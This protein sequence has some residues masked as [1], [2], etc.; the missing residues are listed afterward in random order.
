[1]RYTP[2]HKSITHKKIVNTASELFRDR[3]IGGV[4]V[5]DLMNRAGLTHGGFYA[6]FSSKE[7]LAAEA[8][9][10]AF[11]EAWQRRKQVVGEAEPGRKFLTAIQHYLTTTHRDN[12]AKG[13]IAAALASEVAHHPGPIRDAMTVGVKRWIAGVEQM[14]AEDRLDVDAHTTIATMVGAMVLSRAMADP[15]VADRFISSVRETLL[16]LARRRVS[17]VVQQ[18][19]KTSS[20][21]RAKRAR[22]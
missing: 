11:D 1:M 5:S 3:S 18:R 9:K 14:I 2:Q 21:K 8:I 4:G 10:A 22:S 12:S 13:C 15:A 16:S 6:H 20:K 7:A 19:S 17:A